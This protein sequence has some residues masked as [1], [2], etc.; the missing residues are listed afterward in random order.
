M[1][2][3]AYFVAGGAAF[4]TAKFVGEFW[5]KHK[6]LEEAAAVEMPRPALF[7]PGF[8][9]PIDPYM[10]LTDHL[11]ADGK[12]GGRPY[13]VR[14]GVIYSDPECTRAVDAPSAPEARV[15]VVMP[16]TRYD[17]PP[18]FAEQLK[19]D[20]EAVNRFTGS[21]AT[22]LVGYSMGG[23][24]SR[25]FLH[26]SRPEG[27][28]KLLMVGTPNQGS[29]VGSMAHW[30]V[31]ND[32]GWAMALANHAPAALPALEWL[33]AVPDGNPVLQD[34]NA[35]WSQQRAL[36]Q[37]ARVIGSVGLPTP[38]CS[39]WSWSSGDTAVEKSAL[40]LPG[41]E[42][43]TVSGGLTKSHETLMADPDVFREMSGFLGWKAGPDQKDK[44]LQ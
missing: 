13:Y 39:P 9:T 16:Y 24:S 3:S 2:K 15:F 5:Q 36:V 42:V 32:V 44:N 7:V 17:T 19:P 34:L 33:R 43:R 37:D 1:K 22:D 29:R 26:Q 23:I 12:N 35:R 20:L 41:L 28:G 6:G 27:V 18:Q 40:A 30:A 38:G 14:N 11:T 25:L 4:K 21:T 31:Q 8:T 10:P